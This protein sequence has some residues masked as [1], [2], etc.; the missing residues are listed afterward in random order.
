MFEDMKV[1]YASSGVQTI[2]SQPRLKLVLITDRAAGLALEDFEQAAE[3]SVPLRVDGLHARGVVDVGHRREDGAALLEPVD[4]AL[5][6]FPG[7]VGG[8][9]GAPAPGRRAA[10]RD[11]RAPARDRS[12]RCACSR[13]TAGANGRKP[14]RNLIFTLI[15]CACR[16]NGRR[17]GCCDCPGRA[18]RIPCGPGTSRSRCRR[19]SRRRSARTAPRLRGAPT[20]RSRRV[21]ESAD[22]FVVVRTA[23]QRPVLASR[24][25]FGSRG[26]SRS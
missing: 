7:G 10:C 9:A 1:A 26:W 4:P 16:R 21:Q 2:G 22:L 25:R 15:M 14:S 19:R 11:S 6:G 8:P 23:Q 3:Q 17:P 24:A 5:S 18:A 12:S 20:T 13:S